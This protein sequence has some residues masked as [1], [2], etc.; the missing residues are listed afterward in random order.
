MLF[1]QVKRGQHMPVI[2]QLGAFDPIPN[3]N[4]EKLVSL[5]LERIRHWIGNGAN[6]SKPVEQLLGISGYFPV[7]PT[8]Y[9]A[10]WRNRQ[11]EENKE[12]EVE[13]QQQQA[14]SS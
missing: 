1:Y 8:T 2:E 9:M 11:A 3:Q 7:H 5:N 6:V 14:Q 10:A 4:N 12:P 13:Q